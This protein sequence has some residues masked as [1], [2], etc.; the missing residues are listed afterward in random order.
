MMVSGE[1]LGCQICCLLVV[2]QWNLAQSAFVSVFLILLRAGLTTCCQDMLEL[3]NLL[4]LQ[5]LYVLARDNI[6]SVDSRPALTDPFGC[7]RK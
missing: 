6:T 2:T 3:V 7:S 1:K 5:R 4:G